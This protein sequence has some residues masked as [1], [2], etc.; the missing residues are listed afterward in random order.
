MGSG[1]RP[2]GLFKWAFSEHTLLYVP[3]TLLILPIFATLEAMQ[4]ILVVDDDNLLRRII[5]DRLKSLGYE[6]TTAMHGQEGLTLA[7]QAPPDMIVTDVVMPHMDGV[8]LVRRVRANDLLAKT[9]ILMLTSRGTSEDKILGLDSGADDYLTKPFDPQELAA[10]V[11]ALFR[12]QV[13]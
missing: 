6:V 4:K 8:E 13:T 7:E 3:T 1:N 9:L 12:R 10:R 2:A 5:G 11:K